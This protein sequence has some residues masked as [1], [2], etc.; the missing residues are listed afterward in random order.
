MLVLTRKAN[1]EIVIN[2]NIRVRVLSVDGGR[3]RLGVEAPRSIPVERSEIH[4]ADDGET[5]DARPE[6]ARFAEV[7]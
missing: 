5:W 4:G 7:A 2:G 3:I 1:Q 6:T